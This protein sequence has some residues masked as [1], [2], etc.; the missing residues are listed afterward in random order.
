MWRM[1]KSVRKK[2]MVGVLF[3]ALQTITVILCYSV[4]NHATKKSYEV[5]LEEKSRVITQA[6]RLVYVTREAVKAG[7]YFTEEN[8]ERKYMLSEQNPEGIV[9][10]IQGLVCCADL[11]EGVIVTTPLCSEIEVSP[12]ERECILSDVEFS[13]CFRDGAMIDVRIRYDNGENYCVVRK[14]R[15]Q[16]DEQGRCVLFLTEEEQLLLSGGQYD[17]RVYDGAELY[18]VGFR[19]ERLQES[20]ESGYLPP[21]QVL[22]QLGK[23]S[24]LYKDSFGQWCEYR[25]ELEERLAEHR[26]KSRDG[27]L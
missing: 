24:T 27:E 21:V 23:C 1:R 3:V 8:T 11:P 2:W 26:Q 22:L 13:D 14:K 25:M 5:L 12:S 15:L 17:V 19:E 4:T 9:T 18:L 7:E 16:R 10:E 20:M 6:Q